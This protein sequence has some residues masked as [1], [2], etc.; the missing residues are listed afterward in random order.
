MIVSKKSAEPTPSSLSGFK[1]QQNLTLL[2]VT[3]DSKLNWNTHVKNTAKKAARR[4]YPLK[5]MKCFNNITKYK[6]IQVYNSFILSVLEYNSAL[7]VGINEK[8]STIPCSQ[9]VTPYHM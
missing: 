7:F 6:L 8:N 1:L 5:Q 4:I 9:A 3:F 2:G